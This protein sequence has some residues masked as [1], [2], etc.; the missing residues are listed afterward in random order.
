MTEY[1]WSFGREQSSGNGAYDAPEDVSP[2]RGA[3]P[4][5]QEAR[6]GQGTGICEGRED[7]EVGNAGA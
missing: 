4:G 1:C 7:K 6:D 3:V 2:I 5:T